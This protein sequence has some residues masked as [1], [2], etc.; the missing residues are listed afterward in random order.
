MKKFVTI[1]S[2]RLMASHVQNFPALIAFLECSVAALKVMLADGVTLD[3]A[4]GIGDGIYLV[5]TD[6]D[7]AKKYNMHDATY[8]PQTKQEQET[9]AAWKGAKLPMPG[10]DFM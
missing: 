3:P 10:Q 6:P 8:M 4:M 5:T 7:I 2:N 9:C 1:W